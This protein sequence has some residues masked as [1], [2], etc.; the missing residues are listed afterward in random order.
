MAG[1]E[2]HA[3]HECV[4]EAWRNGVRCQP[5][6]AMAGLIDRQRGDHRG[7]IVAA[8]SRDR[9]TRTPSPPSKVLVIAERPSKARGLDEREAQIGEVARPVSRRPAPS[10]QW[11]GRVVGSLPGR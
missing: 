10:W 6:M 11:G 5:L 9:I 7:A 1:D 2:G 3:H 4:Y 8:P